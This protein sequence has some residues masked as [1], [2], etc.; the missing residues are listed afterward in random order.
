MPF[1]GTLN[2][3]NLAFHAF[4][5]CTSSAHGIF[6]ILV[7]DCPIDT[8]EDLYEDLKSLGLIRLRP[9]DSAATGQPCRVTAEADK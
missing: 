9:M 8:Y 7:I 1:Q 5:Y 6:D 3:K 4:S 2:P